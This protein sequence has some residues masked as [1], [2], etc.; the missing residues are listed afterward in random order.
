M[1]EGYIQVNVEGGIVIMPF[2]GGETQSEL[3]AR[4][5]MVLEDCKANSEKKTEALCENTQY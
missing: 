5:K 4:V 2:V 1:N 3:N